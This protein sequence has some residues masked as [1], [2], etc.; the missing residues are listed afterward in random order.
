[1]MAVGP[2]QQSNHHSG[3]EAI[4]ASAI[5]DLGAIKQRQQ[6]TWASGDFAAVATPMTIVGEML[7]EAVDLRAGSTVLDV[8]CGSGNAALAAARRF[9][10]V[11]GVDYV[12]ALLE[13][14]RERAAAERLEVEFIEGDAEAL[15]FDDDTFDVVL[16][17][18]GVM[19]APDH[20]R[21]AAELLRVC[22]SGGTIGLAN[23]TPE[24]AVGDMFRLT[25]RYAPP[26]PPGLQPPVLWGTERH[27][28][29]LLGDGISEIATER[30]MFTLRYRS[31]EHW[32]AYFR[33]HFGP[34]KRTFE[35]LDAN[36]RDAYAADLLELGTRANRADDGTLVSAAEYLEVVATRR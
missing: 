28:T 26:S 24:G 12:P 3:N 16:S 35:A 15:P 9:C 33:E 1:M 23:W 6:Q 22:R 2:S 17:T 36:G 14:G 21:A 13:R 32:L 4:M 5:P 18:F 34:V 19:F 11:T 20:A 8:A 25:S 7:C 27:L 10:A 30:R 31:P 29:E